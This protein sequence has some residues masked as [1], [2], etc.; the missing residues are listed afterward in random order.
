MTGKVSL[1][2]FATLFFMLVFGF[3]S[4]EFAGVLQYSVPVFPKDGLKL[5]SIL[6]LFPLAAELVLRGL[7]WGISIKWLRNEWLAFIGTAML[8]VVAQGFREGSYPVI[9][10]FGLA[11]LC[12]GIRRHLGLSATV[13][14][15]L[16]FSF[17]FW[18]GSL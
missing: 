6:I 18:F 10:A 17:G 15:H 3:A 4:Y 1:G 16:A 12:S 11:L 2:F 7:L 5:L 14:G 13:F 9:S 8:F